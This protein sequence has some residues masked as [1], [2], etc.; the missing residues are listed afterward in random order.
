MKWTLPRGP[1]RLE[2]IATARNGTV[3]SAAGG[4]SAR[5]GGKVVMPLQA[6]RRRS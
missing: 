2:A 3:R 5:Q 1:R 4:R 6:H